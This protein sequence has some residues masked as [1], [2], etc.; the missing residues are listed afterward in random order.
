MF[1]NAYDLKHALQ[2]LSAHFDEGAHERRR[3][4]AN[5][6]FTII[7]ND[8]WGAEVY[9]DLDLPFDTPLIGTFLVDPCFIALC[10]DPEIILRAPLRF[11]ESSRYEHVNMLRKKKWFPTGTLGDT[12]EVQF[13]HFTSEAEALEKWNRR[14]GRSHFDRLFFKFSADND[15]IIDPAHLAAFDALPLRKIAF[16]NGKHLG[17]YES[18]ITIPEYIV[19]GKSMYPISLKHFDIVAWLNQA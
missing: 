1:M 5:K 16:S 11:V 9:K 6:R 4:L 13:L 10:H 18:V 2:R 14:L 17:S 7:S 12:V 8:C 15:P 3:R 19:D